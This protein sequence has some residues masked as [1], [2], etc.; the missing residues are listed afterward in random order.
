MNA[1]VGALALRNAEEQARA[2]GRAM[3]AGDLRWVVRS[4]YAPVV[5]LN[6]GA[7]RMEKTMADG[8]AQMR[9]DGVTFDAVTVAAPT[10]S[11]L[12]GPRW[13][14]IVPETVTLRT[15]KS[16]LVQESYLLAVS[17]DAGATWQF[18]DGA[19]LNERNLKVVLPDAPAALKLPAKKPT[20][21]V[22]LGR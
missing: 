15:P 18:I 19:G 8:A 5:E 9:K 10:W 12:S 6:G 22:P 13:Y 2:V 1:S 3:L 7:E 20:R 14:A 11:H 16:R 21:Q 4:T 17:D